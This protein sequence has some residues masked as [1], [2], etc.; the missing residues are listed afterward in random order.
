MKGAAIVLLGAA[1]AWGS[2][3]VLGCEPRDQTPLGR[4]AR[5]FQ[6]TCSGCHGADGRGGY[7][8]GLVRPPRD[9][10]RA[11]FHAATTDEQ[12][13]QVIRLGKNE[14]PAFGG[15]L[16]DEDISNV[17]TFIRSL[18]PKKPAAMPG[19]A[20]AVGAAGT[21]S[22]AAAATGGAAGAG[23]S[24]PTSALEPRAARR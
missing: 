3:S 16:A 21:G 20:G 5:T 23:P 13:R 22:A 1:L 18:P 14:M 9:L 24:P 11:E 17:I 2:V 10:T 12:L 15:L 7:R 8:P 4:G 19:A 6:R